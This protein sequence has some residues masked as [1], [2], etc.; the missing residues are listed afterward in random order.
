[1]LIWYRNSFLASVVSIAGS[2]A[3][4]VAIMMLFSGEIVAG[5]GCAAVAAVLLYLG[6]KISE[7]KSFDKWWKQVEK[8]NLEPEIRRSRETAVE[9]YRKNPEK[10]TLEKIR[11]LNPAAAVFIENG[12]R[13]NGGTMAPAETARPVVRAGK[14][15][16]CTNCGRQLPAGSKFCC[17]CGSAVS[18]KP[19][20]PVPTS[21]KDQDRQDKKKM[22]FLIIAL[23]VLLT[24]LVNMI[25]QDVKEERA[26]APVTPAQ[27]QSQAQPQRK[28]V[29][30][31]HGET[32]ERFE[33]ESGYTFAF[34]FAE[35]IMGCSEFTLEYELYVLDGEEA[36]GDN[37]LCDVYVRTVEG[38]WEMAAS[39]R[40]DGTLACHRIYLDE[41]MDLES[42]AVVYHA[43][44]YSYDIRVYDPA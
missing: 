1:M 34:V 9:I 4:I 18:E 24:L 26:A 31:K 38:A 7:K 29:P 30:V 41:A 35:P 21:P 17:G 5:I 10:R 6:K 43:Q 40:M 42:V 12:F 44:P 13:E 20:R 19:A 33:H 14:Q 23:A 8:A 36:P 2:G 16:F 37:V 32:P 15:A 27:T 22:M 11:N 3:G 25:Y 39:F 28:K